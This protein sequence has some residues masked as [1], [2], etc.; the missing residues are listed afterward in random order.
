M[1]LN[2]EEINNWIILFDVKTWLQQL[3]WVIEP[4]NIMLGS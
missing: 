1:F 3:F 2:Q 4:L